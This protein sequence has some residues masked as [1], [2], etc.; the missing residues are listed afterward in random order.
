MSDAKPSPWDWSE[1]Q[2]RH[3]VGRAR[4]G[5]SLAPSTWPGGARCAVSLSFD[6]DHETIPLRDSDESPMRIS[7]G[8]YGARQ[9]IPRIRALLARHGVKASFFYPAVSALLHPDEIRAVADEGHEIGIHSWI[10]EA[11]TQLPPGV[12]R[13]LTFRAADTLER[14]SGRRPVGIRTASWDFSVDTMSIIQELGLLYDSSLMADDDPYELEVQGEPTGIVELPPEWI[15]DDAVYFNMLRFS[16]LRPYT[17]PSAVEEIFRA[18]FEGALAEG[19]LFL[20]TMHPHVIGHRSR[21]ALLDRLVTHMKGTPGVWFGTHEE[22]ARWCAQQA[23]MTQR[24]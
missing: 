4:A 13:D 14:L 7:Q 8:Q 17:P 22:V 23:G 11:N 12:E 1:P 18:E 20:L 10:H 16:G 24:A 2:W 5:R 9:G 6:A 21:I 3:I 19:G 15:R